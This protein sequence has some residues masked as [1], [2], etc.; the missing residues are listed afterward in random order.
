VNY[1]VVIIGSGFGGLCSAIKLREAGIDNIVILEKDEAFGGTWR[2]NHYPGA[3]CDVP[4]H[5]YSFSF[6]QNAGWSRLFPRQDELLAYTERIVRDYE[7]APLIRLG[8]TLKSAHFDEAEGCWHIETNKGSMTARAIVSAFGALSR[9]SIPHFEGIEEFR[10]ES[11]HSAVWKHDV[12]LRGKRVAV[13]GN[14]ASA[15]QF[16]PEIVPKVASLDHYQ[17]TAHWVLP[18][19]DRPV[20]GV[21]KWLL[22]HAKPLQNLYR[23]KHYSFYES[24][25]LIFVFAPWFARLVQWEAK[26]FLKKQVADPALRAK[27]TPGYVLGCKRVLLASNYY[28]ALTQ[29][30]VSVQ[31]DG[32]SEIRAHSI[33][34]SRGEERPVDVLIFATGFDVAHGMAQADIRGRNG[35]ELGRAL[36]EDG[37]YKGCTVA[38]FPNFFMITGPN[39]G[40]G[41]NS[42]IYMIESGVRYA[43]DAV[44]HLLRKD[45]HS[46][47][48]HDRAQRAYNDALQRRLRGTVWNTGCKSWYLDA[49]GRNFVLW[50]GFTF[51]YRRITKRFD[52][53]NYNIQ[54]R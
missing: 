18:R 54:G 49:Q 33:V 15:V 47:E 20:R 26:R 16:I 36:A 46:I 22:E 28:P 14:G 32:I 43:V 11:F 37:A 38:G 23:A 27:L 34:T 48:V 35:R 13:I 19:P 51:H 42:M 40:L 8:T 5:L 2:V 3:A 12:D 30:H 21:E 29:P 25:A 44:R 1:D 53:N 17:R 24:R 7:L 10:G 45:V 52:S 50:P 9:P 31:T 6:A 41:H 39:T 4:S